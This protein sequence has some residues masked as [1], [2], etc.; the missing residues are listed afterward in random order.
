MQMQFRTTAFQDKLALVTGASRGIGKAIAMGLGNSSAVVVGSATTPEGAAKI[1][2]YLKA[3]NIKGMGVVL[4]LSNPESIT[5][6]L[7]T[8]E[9]Q[10]GSIA[11]LV[12]NAGITADNLFLRMKDEEWERVIDANLSG[13]FRI[14]KACVKNMLKAR[15]GRIINISSIVGISG[16]PGQTNYCAAKAGVI[17]FSKALAKEIASRNITVNVVAPGFIDTDMTKDLPETS[18]TKLLEQIPMA[19]MGSADDIANAVLFLAAESSSY[20]TGATINVN[21]GMLMD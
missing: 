19:R 11:I 16:N 14:T 3:A 4:N 20:I 2:E 18:K 9:T 8:I 7:Q 10:F 13:V 21:G 1:T 6:A 17:G 15:W 12:N 5:A